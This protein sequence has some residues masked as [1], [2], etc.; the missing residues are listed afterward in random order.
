M[1]K[2]ILANFICLLILPYTTFAKERSLDESIFVLQSVNYDFFEDTFVDC[3]WAIPYLPMEVQGGWR[4]ELYA[5]KTDG[6]S[7]EV[8]EAGEKIGALG[9]VRPML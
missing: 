3:A 2:I 1:K 9:T 5:L 6:S 7:G 4:S 8:T